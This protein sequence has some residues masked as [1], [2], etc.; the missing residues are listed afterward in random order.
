MKITKTSLS[1][2]KKHGQMLDKHYEI[3]K[4][5]NFKISLIIEILQRAEIIC[6]NTKEGFELYNT[7]NSAVCLVDENE[8]PTLRGMA[9]RY[10]YIECTFTHGLNQVEI[11][12]PDKLIKS[13]V[14]EIEK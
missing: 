9:S 6:G 1:L 8:K 7:E 4:E 11:T 5:Y 14:A 13:I 3:R 2:L 12:N 10:G